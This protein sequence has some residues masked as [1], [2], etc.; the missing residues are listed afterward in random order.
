VSLIERQLGW[1]ARTSLEDGLRATWNW[2][3]ESL[4]DPDAA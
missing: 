4:R 1:R 3:R 2:T